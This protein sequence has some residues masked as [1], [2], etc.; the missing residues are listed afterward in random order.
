MLPEW[1]KEVQLERHSDTL[2]ASNKKQH[3]HYNAIFCQLSDAGLKY[4]DILFMNNF[5]MK[6]LHDLIYAK[7]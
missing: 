1:F 4:Y 3:G 2:I 7:C 5:T 6:K